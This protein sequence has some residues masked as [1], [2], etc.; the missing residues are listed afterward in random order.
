MK[1][2]NFTCEISANMPAINVQDNISRVNQWWAKVFEGSAKKVNDVFT[3]RFG[4]TFVTF[5]LTEFI[6]G[7]KTV[8]HV[9]DCYLP[10]QND[11]TEWNNTDVVFEISQKNNSSH[12][13]FTHAGLVPTV[14]C[15][16][17]CVKGWTEHIKGSLN[18]LLNVGKGDPA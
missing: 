1:E 5:K 13:K 3:V 16:N 4:Q 2:E 9:T 10:F 7:K 6:A 11:K 17:T 18:K 15:Y 12:I 14:E 8:W